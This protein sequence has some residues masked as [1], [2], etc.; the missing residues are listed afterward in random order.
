M[1]FAGACIEYGE[2]VA[3][4]WLDGVMVKTR[5]LPVVWLMA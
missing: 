3:W 1:M 4:L 5:S 2:P